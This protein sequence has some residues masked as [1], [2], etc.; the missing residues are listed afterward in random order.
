[1]FLDVPTPTQ[2]PPLPRI[3]TEGLD[4][5]TL[6]GEVGRTITPL[7]PA[8]TTDFD[9]QRV[10][11]VSEGIMIERGSTVRVVAVEGRRVVVRPV[12][13]SEDELG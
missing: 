7:R 6:M 4:Y 10:D 3:S 8:G 2:D 11:T 12:T 1:M 5:H 9:G 13:V